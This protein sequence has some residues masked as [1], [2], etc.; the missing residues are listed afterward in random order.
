MTLP[1]PSSVALKLQVNPG[2]IARYG[3]TR[4]PDLTNPKLMLLRHRHR[5]PGRFGSVFG[6]LEV[7]E[8]DRA[9]L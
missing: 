6:A 8:L 7:F 9:R 2:K 3:R 4:A 1:E 5:L